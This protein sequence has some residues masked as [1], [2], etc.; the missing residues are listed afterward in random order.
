M[1]SEGAHSALQRP[2]LDLGRRFAAEREW[3][4]R[5]GKGRRRGRGGQGSGR[6]PETAYSR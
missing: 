6:A 4:D 5:K 3:A 1:K 2:W